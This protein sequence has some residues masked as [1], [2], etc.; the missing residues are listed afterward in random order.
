MFDRALGAVIAA[1]ALCALAA[2]A[3]VAAG[4]A[5]YAALAPAIGPAWAAA[6]VAAIAAAPLGVGALILQWRSQARAAETARARQELSNAMA[7]PLFGIV[8]AHPLASIA[9]TLIGGFVAARDPRL[10]RDLLALLRS[11][12]RT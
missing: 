5:I 10:M 7:E 11:W 8:R 1:T 2:L 9:A 4:Y 6:A 3:V 12:P